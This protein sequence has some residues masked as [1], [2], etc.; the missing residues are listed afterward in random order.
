MWF[1]WNYPSVKNVF[2]NL[3]V[4]GKMTAV[5]N[6]M[7]HPSRYISMQPASMT[8]ATNSLLFCLLMLLMLGLL[9]AAHNDAEVTTNAA[10]MAVNILWASMNLQ[11][12]NTKHMRSAAVSEKVLAL[13]QCVGKGPS[14]WLGVLCVMQNNS[15]SFLDQWYEYKN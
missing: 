3:R 6:S 13:T 4:R 12:S 10:L 5:T 14:K 8:R 1:M 9:S 7:A 2:L 15:P 11:A